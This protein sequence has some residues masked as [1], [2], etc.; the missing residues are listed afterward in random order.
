[1]AS[2]LLKNRHC[3]FF[4]LCDFPLKAS[5]PC[6]QMCR[7][8]SKKN[9]SLTFFLFIDP[10]SIIDK[11]SSYRLSIVIGA[12]GHVNN[13]EFPSCCS[14]LPLH[15]YS[16][17]MDTSTISDWERFFQRIQSRRILHLWF[18]DESLALSFRKSIRLY[19]NGGSLHSTERTE[20]RDDSTHLVTVA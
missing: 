3:T 4:A 15:N 6:Q 2:H 17:S 20:S 18:I 5:E 16:M 8:S 19:T 10:F 11:R 7:C 1:M 9:F 12:D 14:S 13:D